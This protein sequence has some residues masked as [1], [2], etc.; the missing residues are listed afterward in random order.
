MPRARSHALLFLMASLLLTGLARGNP[1]IPADD[2]EVLESL[3]L[4]PQ[5]TVTASSA[6]ADPRAALDSALVDARQLI[7][8]ARAEGDPR[9]LGYAEARIT[10][11][12]H[13]PDPIAPVR[14][15]RARLRQATHRF[16]EA[17]AD[18]AAVRKKMPGNPEALLLQASIYQVQGRYAEA[19]QS[20]EGLGG[21]ALEI[22]MICMAQQ[23]SLSGKAAA[24]LQRLQLLSA[25]ADRELTPDQQAWLGLALGDLAARLNNDVLAEQAYR[26]ALAA[27]GP[28]ALATYAD[29]LL[30]H[31]RPAEV[32]TLLQNWTRND[33]LLLRL[34]QAEAVSGNPA[35]AGHIAELQQ[36]FAA[37][38]LR[39][40]TSHQRE[41][42]IFQLTL[43]HSAT[44]ALRL[45][46]SNWTQ[47]REPADVR[48]YLQAARAASSAA[49]MSLLRQWLQ[50]T[51][52]EDRRLKPLLATILTPGAR[53]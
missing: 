25:I 20:C 12:L 29:W 53:T 44:E 38:R 5:L 35:A 52:L 30:D 31:K 50:Q 36:R 15:L 49:D 40:E 9:Y 51:R 6:T 14:L 17:L 33:G 24:S 28:D 23:D 7:L 41:E 19:R 8:Q 43:L 48:I 27:G 22:A 46:R 42:A 3:P 18:I 47:Q 10:P 13:S 16:D 2:S 26:R 39:G 1:R 21:V 32:I 11:W 37:L 34:A 45:A 4:R